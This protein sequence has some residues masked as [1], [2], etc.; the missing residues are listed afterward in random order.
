[1][2]AYLA[3]T[4]SSFCIVWVCDLCFL[5]FE[6]SNWLFLEP[7]LV[8]A[9]AGR[10]NITSHRRCTMNRLYEDSTFDLL[11]WLHVRSLANEL[12]AIFFIVCKL[13]PAEKTEVLFWSLTDG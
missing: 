2:A 10:C 5:E 11:A 9:M 12:D 8:V 6:A 1:M 3:V 4:T 13:Q 7:W